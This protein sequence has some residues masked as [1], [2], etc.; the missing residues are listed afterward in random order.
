MDLKQLEALVGIADHGSFSAAAAALGT[1]QSN[2]SGRIAR[3]ERELDATLVERSSG[4]LT[5]EGALV[6]SRARHVLG[7]LDAILHDVIAARSEVSGTVRAGMIGTTGR[8]LIPRLF[9]TLQERHPRVRLQITEGTSAT[10]EP[11]LLQG[12]LDFAILTTPIQAIE[13]A[14]E[15]LFEED[16]V[17]VLPTEHPLALA[18]ARGS[19]PLPLIELKDFELLLP[20][21]GTALRGEIDQAFEP[22]GA[23]PFQTIELDGLR[24]IA[25][26][27]FDGYGPAVLPATAVPDHLRAQF[28]LLELEGRP[29]RH[30]GVV[31]RRHGLPSAPVRAVREILP[32][33]VIATEA[34]RE[35]IHQPRVNA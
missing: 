29:R 9:E 8:W 13:L 5:E 3:L 30:V 24:T 17:L 32:E 35:G 20:M 7:E 12:Q 21:E 15:P 2:V 4:E 28:R 19:G 26:L 14:V 11:Q 10:L 16:L 6:V 23:T 18:H 25:S 34:R 1:V 31:S 33:I 27:V 22:V